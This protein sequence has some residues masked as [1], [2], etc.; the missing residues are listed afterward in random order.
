MKALRSKPHRL[1]V[2]TV[3][4]LLPLLSFG[5]PWA[6]AQSNTLGMYFISVTKY[7]SSEDSAKR[8]YAAGAYDAVSFFTMIAQQSGNINNQALALY[9]CLNNQ[10]DSLGQLKDWVESA[11]AHPSSD[12]DAIV[13]LIARACN[14]SVSGTPTNFEEIY[15][16]TSRDDSFKHGYAAGIFDATSWFAVTASRTG[17]DNQRTQT[18]FQCLDST[19]DKIV[20]LEQWIDTAL[21]K[22]AANDPAFAGIVNACLL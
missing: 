9:Q 15:Q 18:I 21:G 4:A 20:Q 10:G 16:Y 14:F 7:Q 11:I 19:G 1:T 8:G 5:T 6:L 22:G 13:V 3:L 12:K 2:L 17:I